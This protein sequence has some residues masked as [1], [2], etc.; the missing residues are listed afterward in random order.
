MFYLVHGDSLTELDALRANSLDACVCDPPYDLTSTVERFGKEG[1]APAA[2]GVY[3]RSARGFMGKVWD[4]T[5]IAFNPDLWKKVYR[6]LKPGAHLLA[7]GGTRTYHRQTCAIED[8]GFEVRDCIAWMYG[9]GFPKSYDV[10][11]GIDKRAGVE[12]EVVGEYTSTMFGMSRT[13]VDQGARPNVSVMSGAI[14]A[15][16]TPE[17][18]E[19]AGWGT[20][21]KPAFE[22]IVVARKPLAGTV[23]DNVLAW[24]TGALNIDGCRVGGETHIVHGT[25]AGAFQ[26]LTGKSLKDYREVTGRFPANVLLDQKAAAALDAQS[27]TTV[28]KRAQRGASTKRGF[29]DQGGASRFFYVAK[30]SVAERE[31]GLDDMETDDSPGVLRMRTDGSLDGRKTAPR[32]NTHPTVKPI[33]LMRYL[34]TLVTPP[35]GVVLDP[36][37]GS[38]TTGCAALYEGF[39]FVGIEQDPEYVEIAQRRMAYWGRE[40]EKARAEAAA[41]PTLF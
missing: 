14:T 1:G 5:G 15:P 40:G 20:A 28:R 30:A 31:A 32:A 17:A 13:R 18:Q 19:W 39:D 3:E 23:V 7:F 16:A 37:T 21:L 11:K 34:V 26:P 22:P 27:G 38:G 8:A 33:S 6:V 10:S 29:D 35:G 24:G 9:S 36:F 41:Q 4:G 2:A 25:E 12:R